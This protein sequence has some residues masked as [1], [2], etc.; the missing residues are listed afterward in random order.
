MARSCE[1]ST[2]RFKLR[3]LSRSERSD[4][5]IRALGATPVRGEL[6]SVRS[7]RD[8]RQRSRHSLRGVREAV[9]HARAVLER[10]R[11]RD[12]RQL[13]QAARQAGAQ[14]FI[15]IG[16]EA[17]LFHGQHMRDIDERYPVPG[18]H[19]VPLLR[20]EGGGGEAGARCERAGLRDAVDP[21]A[22][23]VGAGR[24]DDPARAGSDG[25]QRTLRLDRSRPRADLDHAHREPGPRQSSSRSSAAR[26]AT[27]TS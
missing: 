9:G 21:P 12:T 5:A 1:R 3:A 27:R 11:R 7:G 23:R 17:A 22:L 10:E 16:T 14:R 2:D 25:A 26:A 13:L 4:A 8:C 6:G 19:A 18:A 24:S 20:D 15:H